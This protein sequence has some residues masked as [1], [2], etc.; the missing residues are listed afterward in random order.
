MWTN[1][2]DSPKIQE[3]NLP[4]QDHQLAYTSALEMRNSNKQR[5]LNLIDLVM[6]KG[7]CSKNKALL[8]KHQLVYKEMKMIHINQGSQ[9]V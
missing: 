3:K 7:L 4:H 2:R 6:R 8:Q 9:D 1:L 5:K